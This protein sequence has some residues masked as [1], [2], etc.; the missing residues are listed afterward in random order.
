[1]EQQLERDRTAAGGDRAQHPEHDPEQPEHHH[2]DQDAERRATAVA[3]VA[4][5]REAFLT[6]SA[7]G[8]AERSVGLRALRRTVSRRADRIAEVVCRETGKPRVDAVLAEA[9]HAAA[10]ADW[11]A[12][13]ASAALARRKVSPWPLYSKAAWVEYQPRGVAAVIAPWNYPFLL[14]FLA[15]ATALA[16]GCAVVL[17]PSEVAPASGELVAELVAAAGLPDGLVQV[18]HGGPDAGA[19]LVS[20]GVDVVAVTG[21]PSTGRQVAALAAERLTPVILELGGKDPMLVLDDADPG[22]AAR[23]AVWGACFNAG[24]SCVAVERVYAVDEVYDRFVAELDRAFDGVRAGGG[25]SR[26]IG[27]IIH[28][29]QLDV[30][31]GQVKEAVALGATLR[32]GGR[33][34]GEG[35]RFFEPTLL[36]EVDHGMSVMREETFGPVL[37]VM[38][39]PDEATAIRL[40]NDSRFGL[41]ASVWTADAERARRVAGRLRAGAVAINDCLVNYA[42]PGLEFGGVGDSGYGRQGGVEGLRAYCFTRSITWSRMTPRREL[43]WFPRR[44]GAGTWKRAIRLLYGR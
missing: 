5:A 2:P 13:H 38:R 41:H 37:P 3:A 30:I 6:W 20:A 8:A 19:A 1:M 31:E 4:G 14:P 29:P 15:T 25:G 44:L 11:L 12:R 26:D 35:G 43:Q 18:L 42:M 32:R 27:P 40:A 34:S 9:M 39:V 24:Q 36:T 7:L 33:R 28:A 21:S 23:A 10:H 16:A 17:K 22:R